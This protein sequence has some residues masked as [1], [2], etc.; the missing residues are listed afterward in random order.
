MLIGFV[1]TYICFHSPWRLPG[2]CW[3]A[4]ALGALAY[5]LHDSLTLSAGGRCCPNPTHYCVS[6]QESGQ[7]RLTRQTGITCGQ[8]PH[9]T[10]RRA[11]LKLHRPRSRWGDIHLNVSH[12][13]G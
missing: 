13:P 5:Q 3:E 1:H 10:L 4:E 6:P 12:Q 2:L 7:E 8:Y 11:L 9:T